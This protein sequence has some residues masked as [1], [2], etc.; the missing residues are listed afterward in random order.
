MV[1][2]KVKD[3]G[4]RMVY[5]IFIRY[6][7]PDQKCPLKDP[8]PGHECPQPVVTYGVAATSEQRAK[9]RAI[10]ELKKLGPDVEIVQCRRLFQPAPYH[11]SDEPVTV[12]IAGQSFTYKQPGTGPH[13]LMGD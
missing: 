9:D 5:V 13:V 3:V 12:E 6:D 11:R 1:K 4:D 7:L 2:K 10:A 8:P